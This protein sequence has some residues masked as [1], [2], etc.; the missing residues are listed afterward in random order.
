MNHSVF[1]PEAYI[2]IGFEH[3]RDTDPDKPRGPEDLT[4]KLNKQFLYDMEMV[5]QRVTQGFCDRDLWNIGTWFLSLMPVMLQR[6][7]KLCRGCPACLEEDPTEWDKILDE[8]SFLFQEALE[9]TC[10]RKNPYY[11]EHMRQF[12][13]FNERFGMFG[14]RLQTEEELAR[15]GRTGCST[16]HFMRELPEYQEIDE[17]YEAAEKEL[18]EYREQCR[19][20]AMELFTKWMP[21]LWGYIRREAPL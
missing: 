3:E 19:V 4:K 12:S 11:D 21:H 8:M 2:W 1:D 18:E 10:S 14:E 6:Y 16:V 20:K 15:H 9:E 5:K 7:K 17:K 13:E